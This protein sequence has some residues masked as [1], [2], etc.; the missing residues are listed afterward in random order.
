[1]TWS[2][3]E[4]KSAEMQEDRVAHQLREVIQI[5]KATFTHVFDMYISGPHVL[6]NYVRDS[7][8]NFMKSPSSIARL[9]SPSTNAY[10]LVRYL[11]EPVQNY[12]PPMDTGD[13]LTV[14]EVRLAMQAWLDQVH[15]LLRDHLNSILQQLT[16]Q[17]KLVQVR[18]RVWELLQKD[19]QPG[20]GWQQVCQGL[21]GTHYS[22]WN[23]LLRDSINEQAKQ[24]IRAGLHELAQQPKQSVWPLLADGQQPHKGFQLSLPIWPS[25]RRPNSVIT[26][27]NSS[28]VS[29]IESFK[30]MVKQ[31]ANERTTAI[32]QLQSKFDEK[33]QSLRQDVEYHLA[34]R[35]QEVF[36]C[37]ADTEMISFYFQNECSA[38]LTQYVDGLRLLFKDLD[39]WADKKS[40]NDV[41]IVIGRL[42]RTIATLSKELPRA[43]SCF[44]SAVRSFEL[45][46]DIDK[47]TRYL[48]VKNDLLETFHEAH[49]GWIDSVCGEY[50]SAL[51]IA[52][53]TLH[54]NDE[55]AAALLWERKLCLICNFVSFEFPCCFP[56]KP[57]LTGE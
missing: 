26:L 52:L 44:S 50:A 57:R 49:R 35:D 39:A 1:M 20:S 12:S 24:L 46:S 8:T 34:F 19:D 4:S 14:D 3:K 51:H 40:A 13:P 7:Q 18:S 11:P 28:N 15:H 27:P 54:W 5:V 45:R 6:V 55:C 41:A 56:K 16:T 37:K 36:D 53:T 32:E 29:E 17:K 9:F 42:A 21:L 10:L 48:Q 2:T 43:F 38:A 25:S 47:D 33:L 22:I 31:A 23:T 30:R